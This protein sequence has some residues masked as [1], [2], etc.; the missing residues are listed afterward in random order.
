MR[1]LLRMRAALPTG[2]RL[3]IARGAIAEVARLALEASPNETGGLLLG[4]VNPSDGDGV[5]REILGSGPGAARTAT[6]FDPDH[7]WQIEEL[8][9]RYAETVGSAGTSATGTLTQMALPPSATP[10]AGPC[11]GSATIRWRALKSQ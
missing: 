5:V 6:S 9:S 1:R 4:Y 2:G 11:G 3:W 8:A 7:G 10:T